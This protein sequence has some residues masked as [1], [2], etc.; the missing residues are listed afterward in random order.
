MVIL[1]STQNSFNLYKLILNLLIS[2]RWPYL[3]Y[4][5]QLLR[6]SLLSL[7]FRH[8]QLVFFF[9]I[10]FILWLTLAFNS[11]FTYGNSSLLFSGSS[12]EYIAVSPNPPFSI[13]YG[14]FTIQSE[15]GA[16]SYSVVSYA[17]II[18]HNFCI[19]NANKSSLKILGSDSSLAFLT[20]T[21][22]KLTQSL[23]SK[24]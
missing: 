13:T 23:V 11:D 21:T 16:T 19:I 14:P 7:C 2:F 22:L 6:C 12:Y 1:C 10:F 17:F 5:Q 15:T 8:L 3:S 9:T 4:L 18:S 24:K 20:L